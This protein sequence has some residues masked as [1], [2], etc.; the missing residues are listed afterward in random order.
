MPLPFAVTDQNYMEFSGNIIQDTACID[1][2]VESL[3]IG[4]PSGK[5]KDNVVFPEPVLLAEGDCIQIAGCRIGFDLV[6]NHAASC[7]IKKGEKIQRESPDILR[8]TDNT[9]DTPAEK[10]IHEPLALCEPVIG[11]MHGFHAGYP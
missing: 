6:I 5:A 10:S 4:H 11:V 8:N 7:G 9:I 3:L 1:K 2:I